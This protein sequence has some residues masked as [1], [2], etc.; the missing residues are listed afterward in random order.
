MSARGPRALSM[1][2]GVFLLPL[3]LVKG[4]AIMVAE[5][6]QAVAASTAIVAGSTGV[7]S[8]SEYKPEWTLQQ[9]VAADYLDELRELPF[10]PSPLLHIV[11]R[12]PT[13]NPG[14]NT[15]PTVNENPILP[16]P[17][18]TVQMILKSRRGNVALIN[19]R[20]YRVGDAIGSEGWVVQNIDPSTRSVLVML[21]G[22]GR[23]ATLS[24]P[25]PRSR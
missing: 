17:D 15:D 1:D 12:Q 20:R 6:A 8:V 21:P 25:L 4:T 5:P 2:L 24:V 13:P 19:H 9:L 3:L 16:P 14:P 11:E 7:D 18:V 22:T 23:T 10:G